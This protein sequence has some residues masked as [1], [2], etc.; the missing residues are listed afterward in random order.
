VFYERCV[1][2]VSES[3]AIRPLAGRRSRPVDVQRISR[4]VESS[5]NDGE[6]QSSKET[7][8]NASL[9]LLKC[10]SPDPL[11]PLGGL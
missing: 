1:A 10:P 9:T 11:G 2:S 3:G 7:S 5:V 8:L 6:R 4:G